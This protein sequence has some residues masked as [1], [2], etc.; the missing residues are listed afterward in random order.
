MKK[1]NKIKQHGQNKINFTLVLKHR[2]FSNSTAIK[3]RD[4]FHNKVA[5]FV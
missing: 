2:N 3:T 1:T 4:F 5:S